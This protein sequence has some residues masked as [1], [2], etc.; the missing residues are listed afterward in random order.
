MGPVAPENPEKVRAFFYIMRQKEIFGTAQEDGTGIQYIYES[1]GRLINSAQIAGNVTDRK[2]LRLLEN[3]EGFRQLVHSI[4]VTVETDMPSEEITFLFQMYGKKDLYGGGTNLITKVSGDGMERRIYLSDYTWTEDD[5]IP[6]QIKFL[7]PT[8]GRIGKA[9]VRF[10]LQDGY[11][12]AVMEQE[13]SVD[14]NTKEYHDMIERSLMQE[15]NTG[16]LQRA[17]SRAREGKNVTLAYIGGSITQGAGATPVNTE[18]YDYK[19]YQLFQKTF[20]QKENVKFIKAGVG[21]TPSELGM[22]RFDRDVLR[23]GERPDIVV[24]EFAVNDEGDETQGDCYESL[25]RKVLK[26][27]WKP[28]VILLFSVFADDWN[29]QERLKAVGQQYDLPMVS[30][31]DAVTP[32]FTLANGRGRVLTKNQFF[33]DMFHPNNMGHTIMAQCLH[34]LFLQCD[35]TEEQ[36][37]MTSLEKERQQEEALQRKLQGAPVIGNRYEKVRLMDRK[38]IPAGAVIEEGGFTAID[39]E[40]QCVEMDSSLEMTPQFPYNWMYDG[41]SRNQAF[42]ELRLICRALILIYKDSGEVSVGKAKVLV[43]GEECLLADPHRNNWLHCNAVIVLQHKESKEHIVRVEIAEEDRDK[44]FT[45]LG[46]GYVL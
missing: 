3:V 36:E 6:G 23:Q 18:C 37:K 44:S 35:R 39:R 43:D 21:G 5:D 13:P 22:I 26:L 4:G 27:S 40:L 1:D 25:V 24:I 11:E 14:V 20:A 28:A 31:R 45:I 32:Q 7:F 38:D 8:P 34:K 10:Y 29:L 46:F 42:F 33:Y 30:I 12:A 16:R 17:I 41:K 15:G 2:Q 19:S 9:S